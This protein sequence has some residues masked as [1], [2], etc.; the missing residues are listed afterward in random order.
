MRVFILEDDEIMSAN[1]ERILLENFDLMISHCANTLDFTNQYNND[2]T[3][4]LIIDI[5][6]D[7]SN[8]LELLNKFVSTSKPIIF[9][10]AFPNAQYLNFTKLFKNSILL[11]KPIHELSMLSFIM[12]YQENY[13]I[14]Q[15]DYLE[16]GNSTKRKEK[17]LYKNID[18]VEVRGNY[19]IIYAE[20]KKNVIK[21]S[22]SKLVIDSKGILMKLNKNI[23]VNVKYIDNINKEN[24]S[25][26]IM[27]KKFIVS[28]KYFKYHNS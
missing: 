24:G 10:T 6:I 9:I 12:R 5:M 28:E 27:D 11:I 3:D 1:I 15:G 2:N 19:S 4:I 20:N 21:K 8:V 25:I 26:K 22:I 7:N 13:L 14:D 16:V 18:L 17:I 23:A